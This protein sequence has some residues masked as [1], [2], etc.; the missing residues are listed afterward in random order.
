MR[1]HFK[2]GFAKRV[3]SINID[4]DAV[5]YGAVKKESS[6][7]AFILYALRGNLKSFKYVRNNGRRD[8]T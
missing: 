3:M 5:E 4:R 7:L 8:I 2:S 1:E 6:C